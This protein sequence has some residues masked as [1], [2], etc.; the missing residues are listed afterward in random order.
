MEEN[1]HIINNLKCSS[2][3]KDK[4]S[5]NHSPMSSDI[6]FLLTSFLDLIF[7]SYLPCFL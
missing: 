1:K 5:S 2:T 4:K 7:E 6:L 3:T